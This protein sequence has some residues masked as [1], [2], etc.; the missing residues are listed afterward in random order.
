MR[1][2]WP[3]GTALGGVAVARRRAARTFAEAGLD[4]RETQ[5][6]ILL[7][8]ELVTNALVHG[9][10]PVGLVIDVDDERTRIEVKDAATRVPHVRSA[11]VSP[12]GGR[13]LALVDDLATRWG[14]R[15]DDGG[16]TV[17][18]ELERSTPA[19]A[20]ATAGSGW[21]TAARA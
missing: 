17:W 12:L 13:G 4:A 5:V 20:V 18:L 15:V 14:T 16:K 7:V 19:A 1:R 6:L 9:R 21:R 2:V 8:S 3:I 10:P 11:A